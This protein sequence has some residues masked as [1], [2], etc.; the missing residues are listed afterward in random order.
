[1][2]LACSV[3]GFSSDDGAISSTPAHTILIRAS[4]PLF[5]ALEDVDGRVK[6]GQD[7]KLGARFPPL[8]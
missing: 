3:A 6:L 7:E 1:V 5:P 2:A 4:T 8:R